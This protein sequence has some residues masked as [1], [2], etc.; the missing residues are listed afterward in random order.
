[1]CPLCKDKHVITKDDDDELI[2]KL[3]SVSRFGNMRSNTSEPDQIKIAH[4]QK[5]L[6]LEELVLIEDRW[7]KNKDQSSNK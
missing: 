3:N 6:K 2:T 4:E 1:M 7:Y 5:Q